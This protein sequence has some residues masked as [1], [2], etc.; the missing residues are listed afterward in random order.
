M[1][2]ANVLDEVRSSEGELCTFLSTHTHTNL[3]ITTTVAT[4]P[5][6]MDDSTK[7][8]ASTELRDSDD[9]RAKTKKQWRVPRKNEGTQAT[10]QPGDS[11][12]WITCQKGREGK[13]VH[14]LRD[15]FTNYAEHLYA[16]TLPNVPEDATGA[17]SIEND[18]QAELADIKKPKTASLF[19]SV[20]LDMQCVVFF[21]TIPPVEPVSFVQTICEDAAAKRLRVRTRFAQRLTPMTLMGH[22]SLEG[23][24]KVA[25]QVLTPHF[26]GK[27]P[28]KYAIRPHMRNHNMSTRD[29]VIKQ[30]ASAVGPGHSV[31]L[32]HYDLLILAEFYKNVCGMSVVTDS[33]EK[34]KRFNLTELLQIDQDP[35]PSASA[36]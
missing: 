7:R 10:I 19:T 6:S 29:D 13:C 35:M 34:L 1:R 23:L 16:D 32:H 4:S 33:F 3:L 12:I 25:R 28:E 11:G 27:A 8:K 5:V 9:K 17:D 20:R 14:E 15:L 24:E 2:V 21:K 18:I 31:D 36:K 30:I 22:G 26:Q